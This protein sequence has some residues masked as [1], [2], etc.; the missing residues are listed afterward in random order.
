M[1]GEE[2]H[3]A[4]VYD[5]KYGG[6]SYPL[7]STMK[8]HPG[9]SISPR[10]VTSISGAE[11]PLPDPD[12]LTHLQFRRFAGCPICNVHL[13]TFILRADGLAMC[14]LAGVFAGA[15]SWECPRA[16]SVVVITTAPDPLLRRGSAPGNRRGCIRGAG[17]RRGKRPW[18][19]EIRGVRRCL[20]WARRAGRGAR[21]HARI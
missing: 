11:I 9:D 4:P 15:L 6:R 2:E 7:F 3:R 10:V 16:Y 8:K 18:V 12:R 17:G 5:S 13:R 19:R 14:G 1:I 20:R 21:G